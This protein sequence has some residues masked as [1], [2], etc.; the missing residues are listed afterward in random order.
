MCTPM[1]RRL[2]LVG[3]DAVFFQFGVEGGATDLKKV[4]GL[5]DV[6][7]HLFQGGEENFFFRFAKLLG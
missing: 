1:E 2:Y 4:G 5:G 3:T 6:A 7:V